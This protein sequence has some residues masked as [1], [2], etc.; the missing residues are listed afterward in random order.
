MLDACGGGISSC[1][2]PLAGRARRS[3]ASSLPRARCKRLLDRGSGDISALAFS[4]N[5][6]FYYVHM[7]Q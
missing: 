7:K 2:P 6:A 3:E 5:P 1:H 4:C